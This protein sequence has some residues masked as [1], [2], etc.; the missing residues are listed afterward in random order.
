MFA[1]F[2]SGHKTQTTKQTSRKRKP[3]HKEIQDNSV[4]N[5]GTLQIFTWE[6]GWSSPT[7]REFSFGVNASRRWCCHETGTGEGR[8]FVWTLKPRI[9]IPVYLAISYLNF[10]MFIKYSNKNEIYKITWK[11]WSIYS[12]RER[13]LKGLSICIAGKDDVNRISGGFLAWTTWW[14]DSEYVTEG[15]MRIPTDIFS[16]IS[17]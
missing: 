7:H 13:I 2:C 10:K 5:D 3:L 17:I 1:I 14:F 15:K 6:R 11:F 12:I 16:C 4:W 8:H 9:L